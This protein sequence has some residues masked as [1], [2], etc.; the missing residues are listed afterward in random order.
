MKPRLK[1]RLGLLVFVAFA[2]VLTATAKAGDLEIAQRV[3]DNMRTGGMKHYAIGVGS[4]EGVVTLR[5]SVENDDQRRLALSIA[6]RIDGVHYVHDLLSIS[7][8][9]TVR[10]D[11]GNRPTVYIEK[12]AEVAQPVI[13]GPVDLTA[14]VALSA[15]RRYLLPDTG[16]FDVEL[17]DGSRIVARLILPS[18]F[19][20]ETNLG[21]M[22]VP[23]TL[24][25]SIERADG[26]NSVHVHLSNGDRVTGR[27]AFEEGALF[28]LLAAHGEMRV[29]PT[30]IISV[31]RR[32]DPND[33]RN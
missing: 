9:D 13:L 2:L 30:A 24:V 29:V 31:T 32:E 27:I 7:G 26:E 3:A 18:R 15:M 1:R 17:D 33:S 14:Y 10:R 11:S 19:Q 12:H 4:R 6:R 25:N 8:R 20:L 21:K 5:G 22:T 28:Q 23:L 16:C